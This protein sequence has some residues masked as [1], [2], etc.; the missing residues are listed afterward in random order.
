MAERQDEI[1][2]KRVEKAESKIV[3]MVLPVD[4]VERHVAQCVVHPAHV[5]FETK[6]EPADI[7]RARHHWP[8]GRFLRDRR[9][10]CFSENQ[11]V[12]SPQERDRFE[13][14]TS[15]K[16]IWDPFSL[17]AAVVEIKHRPERRRYEIRAANRARSTAESWPLPGGHSYRSGCSTRGE[18][19][20]AGRHA[21]K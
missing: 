8:S 17:A 10:P 11:L 3:V 12:R 19:P 4:R 20:G 5:P 14:F 7:G 18:T 9:R 6:A 21:H 16:H 13:V 15:A 1:L 2:V